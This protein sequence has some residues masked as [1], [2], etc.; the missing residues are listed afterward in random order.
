MADDEQPAV[1]ADLRERIERVG[2]GEAGCERGVLAQQR[3]LILPPRLGGE[4]G[5]L[6]GSR[7]RAE[8]DR[9]EARVQPREGET[10]GTRLALASRGQAPL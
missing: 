5:G 2:G 7:L 3:A 9:L 1:G 8:E 6:P 4:L 10:R